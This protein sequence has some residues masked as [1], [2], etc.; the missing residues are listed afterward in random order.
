MSVRTFPGGPPL[1]ATRRRTE[2]WRRS[3]EQLC[4]R[5]GSLEIAL[6]Q[7]A[8]AATQNVDDDGQESSARHLIWRVRLLELGK[9]GI[10]VEQ[11]SALGQTILLEDDVELVAVIAIGQNRWMFRTRV[12]NQVRHK[13]NDRV[14]LSAIS[15]Q[16]PDRVERC[17]R[18]SFYRVSTAA[19]SLPQVQLYSLLDPTTTWAAEEDS[20]ARLAIAAECL[21]R[22]DQLPDARPILPEVGPSVQGVLLNVGGG[23][24]G[25]QVE[26]DCSGVVQSHRQFWLQLVLPPI[27]N[28]PFG[29]SA[30]LA[31]IHMDSAQNF[32]LGMQFEFGQNPAY[33]N[34]VV[35]QVC[36]YVTE[37]QREQLRRLREQQEAA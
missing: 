3:L 4:E 20:R 17:Q 24:V 19:L 18:R 12:Q 10:V 34:F 1:P 13:L 8:E 2:N 25:V 11:P 30:R 6:L 7:H 16:W 29:V 28:S 23:G 14:M 27:I 35:D 33:K 21:I 32:Y 15:L 22:G 26:S 5:N 31:H 37:T 9:D 36:R